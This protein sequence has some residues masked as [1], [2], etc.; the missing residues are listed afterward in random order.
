LHDLVI[1][2]AKL[3]DGTGSSAR[4]ADIAIDGD[5]ITEVGQVS[6]QAKRSLDADGLLVTPG[7]VDIHTHYDAQITWDPQLSPS[8][9]HGVTTTI[10]GNCGVGFAPCAPDRRRYLIE[11]MEGVE[12]IPG[13][14]MEA[15]LRWEWETFPEYLDAVD[16]LEFA[17]DVGAHI[18]HGAVR[19]YAM[20]ERGARNE[21]ATPA[22]IEAM[23]AIVREAIEAGAVGFSTSRTRVHR[24]LNGEP[25]PGTFAGEEELF[26][27]GRAMGSLG[28]G[29]FEVAQEGA[30]GE[31]LD[32]EGAVQRELD[33]MRRLSAETGRPVSFVVV[34]NAS[35]PEVWREQLAVAERATAEGANMVCQVSGRPPGVLIGLQGVYHPFA[36][37]PSYVA[38]ESLPL[39]ERVERLRGSDLKA[40]LLSEAGGDDSPMMGFF[41]DYTG[42]FPVGNPP[43]YEPRAED[44][45][46]ARARAAGREPMDVLYDLLLEDGGKALILRP[47]GNYVDH[48]IDAIREMLEHPRA[49]LS[50]ADGG[51]HCGMIADASA[52]TFMLSYW[53]RD[54]DR[55]PR[56]PLERVVQHMTHDTAQVYGLGDRGSV[57]P[58]MK[59]DINL[60]DFENLSL[61]APEMRFDLPGGG[62]RLFQGASGY[63]ATIVSGV[64][65]QEDDAPTGALPGRLLRS[66]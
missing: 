20:G 61:I 14:A 29:V 42:L 17:M 8:G 34:Q 66:R 60:I 50:L 47:G 19:V 64:V 30:V 5:R 11:L 49:V 13:S 23:A 44:S 12:D 37:C 58:G 46:A 10:F 63:R 6:G 39:Q 3:V 33:W 51:A 31:A 18:A 16:R 45:V 15:G 65:T 55:G 35:E 53:V 40:R 59:A 2:A 27:I 25:V 36:R 9:G 41:A 21:A 38:I 26:G 52:P 24:A 43:C 1:R 62:R 28:K 57:A 32:S 22:D 4:T 7:F 54:R 48:S 56:L